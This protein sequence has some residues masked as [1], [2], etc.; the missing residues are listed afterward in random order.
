MANGEARTFELLQISSQSF[1]AREVA[2]YGQLSQDH[3]PIHSDHD[4][5][6]KTPFRHPI[7]YGFLFVMP[8]W[9]AI[10]RTFGV[11][12]LSSSKASIR[13]Q[14]PLLVGHTAHYASQVEETGDG[15]VLVFRITAEG[16]AP[17]AVV[18]V[19]LSSLAQAR[20]SH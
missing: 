3:N 10:E 11:E 16:G 12:A 9:E 8:I 5:A 18:Q 6:A 17:I 1:G 2:I 14:R 15:S 4:F 7:V 20:G 19:L 13:F